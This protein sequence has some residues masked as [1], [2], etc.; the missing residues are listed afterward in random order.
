ALRVRIEVM[1][2]LEMRADQQYHFRVCVIGDGPVEA[3]PELVAFTTA[4]RTDV[5]MRVVTVDAPRGENTFGE[6]VFA[7][8]ANVIHDL[9]T[10]VLDDRVANALRERIERL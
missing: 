1:P 3:H 6:P 10:A 5:C 7:G 9:L 8:P 2:R 4:R